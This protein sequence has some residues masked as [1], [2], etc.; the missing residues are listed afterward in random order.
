MR[1]T[2]KPAARTAKSTKKARPKGR[3]AIETMI[4][5]AVA[6]ALA[7][8]VETTTEPVPPASIRRNRPEP[9]AAPAKAK[10]AVTAEAPV[11]T[12]WDRGFIRQCQK[13]GGIT[14]KQ[15]PV[16]ERINRKLIA[17]NEPAVSLPLRDKTARAAKPKA[18]LGRGFADIEL[19]RIVAEALRKAPR[20]LSMGGLIDALSGR[21]GDPASVSSLHGAIATLVD[22]GFV[23]KAE[24]GGKAI[25][26]AA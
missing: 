15:V 12:G 25:Y 10:A 24:R 22:L 19:T 9:K 11:I 3:P 17:N 23:R 6:E 5:R 16:L 1:K 21:E 20:G 18:A 2:K 7:A 8:A 26:I 4:A 13:V 14:A